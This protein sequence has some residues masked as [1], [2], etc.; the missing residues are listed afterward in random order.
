MRRQCLVPPAAVATFTVVALRASTAFCQSAAENDKVAAEM[1]FEEGRRLAETNKYSEACPKFADSQKLDPSAATLLNLANCLEKLG[2]TATAW[3]TFKQAGSLAS[4]LGR[5]DYVE[6]AD[7]HANALF[8]RASRLIVSVPHAVDG[9][10]VKRDGAVLEHSEWGSPIPIDAG[11][12]TLVATGPGYASWIS[13]VDI[14]QD[15][16]EVTVAVPLLQA[17]PVQSP[18]TANAFPL[19]TGT[20]LMPATKGD[21]QHPG[22]TRRLIGW[23]VVGGGVA[24]LGVGT[25]F[26]VMA[27]DKYHSSMNEMALGCEYETTVCDPGV[28]SD[29]NAARTYGDISSWTL[30]LGAAAL[31]GGTVIWITAPRGTSER[32]GWGVAP[33]PGGAVVRGV[34]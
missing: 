19:A 29:R 22:D 25:V 4:A 9:M 6:T 34:W 2:R 11:S 28:V 3:A 32:V 20:A 18:P 12:H 24:S 14:A 23:M 7:R 31:V 16:L 17:L 5:I 30:G 15:G 33:M 26:G 21:L 8:P 13:T 27:I 1:L 10:T